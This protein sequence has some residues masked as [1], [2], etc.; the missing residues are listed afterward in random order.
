MAAE[1]LIDFEE[2]RAKLATL[3]E[4]SE[5]A[6]RELDNLKAH[7]ERIVQLE[8]E[9]DALLEHYE[10]VAPEALDALDDA[11]RGCLYRKLHLKAIAKEDG[12]VELEMPGSSLGTIRV[13]KSKITH[14]PC[15]SRTLRNRRSA[16]RSST[17]LGSSTPRS[18]R[19]GLRPGPTSR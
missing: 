11:Q 10:Q 3:K 18:R 7:R 19:P 5:S 8:A 2:L 1:G 17:A 12:S 4:Q 6:R 16:G 15:P 9:R 14:H 13:S